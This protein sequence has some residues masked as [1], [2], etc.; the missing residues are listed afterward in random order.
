[1]YLSVND[2]LAQLAEQLPFKQWVWSSNVQR[3]TKK[4]KEIPLVSPSLFYRRRFEKSNRNSPVE[5]YE[6]GI[7]CYFLTFACAV[8][9][10]YAGYLRNAT[11]QLWCNP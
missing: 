10:H 3:V 7:R 4:E 9:L 11:L 5:L 6:C 2:P 8:P 1:M